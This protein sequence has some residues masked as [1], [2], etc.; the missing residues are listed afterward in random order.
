MMRA[1]DVTSSWLQLHDFA[2]EI[3]VQAAL[4]KLARA[5]LRTQRL[6]VVEK[7][8]HRRMLLHRLEHVAEAAEHMRADRL[9]L[10]RARP[11]PGQPALVGGDAKMVGPEHHEALD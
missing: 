8:Q 2:R 10:E 7:E 6:L 9:A 11:H 5:R 4:A 3:F 1:S